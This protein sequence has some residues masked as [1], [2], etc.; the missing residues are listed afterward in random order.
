MVIINRD[1]IL[2]IYRRNICYVSP[3]ISRSLKLLRAS[4]KSFCVQVLVWGDFKEVA[5]SLIYE[6][7]WAKILRDSSRHSFSCSNKMSNGSKVI[8]ERCSFAK[9]LSQKFTLRR[10]QNK[11]FK[12]SKYNL[13]VLEG[14]SLKIGKCKYII[15][16]FIQNF[17]M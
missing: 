9:L 4:C 8:C 15:K 13:G 3:K 6:V 12:W 10:H 5:R 16:T 7:K 1:E 17:V 2:N 14:R 11:F